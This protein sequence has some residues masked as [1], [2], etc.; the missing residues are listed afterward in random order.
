VSS[1]E[2]ERMNE[3]ECVRFERWIKEVDDLMFENMT[4]SIDDLEDQ[5]YYDM[6]IAGLSPYNAYREVLAGIEYNG[7]LNSYG[8]E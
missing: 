1:K 4:V 3:S 5:P 7:W 2:K 6:Y 8:F